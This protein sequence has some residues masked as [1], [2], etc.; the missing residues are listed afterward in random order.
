MS[1]MFYSNV[2]NGLHCLDLTHIGR[3]LMLREERQVKNSNML[4]LPGSILPH[5]HLYACMWEKHSPTV[6]IVVEIVLDVT[7]SEVE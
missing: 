4:L 1:G 7:A 5:S 2:R 6:D 3:W